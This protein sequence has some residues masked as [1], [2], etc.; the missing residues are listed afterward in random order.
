MTDDV[1]DLPVDGAGAVDHVGQ[2]LQAVAG[3]DHAAFTRL[4]DLLAPRVFGLVLR[5]L[6]DRAQSEEVLQDVFLEI[7]QSA[8]QFTPNKGRGRSWIFTI[9]HR[10]AVDRVRSAQSSANRDVRVGI[11][12]LD[13]AHDG[14]AEDAELRIEGRRA[15]AALAALPSAQR[16]AL[17]LAYHSGYSQSEIAALTQVPLGTVKTRMREGLARLRQVMGGD[18]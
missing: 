18:G 15:T 7:W 12:D 13:V 8:A 1:F 10:R 2:L 17:T 16:E 14:V 11:R 6:V 4:Y 5:V 9:A 3:G